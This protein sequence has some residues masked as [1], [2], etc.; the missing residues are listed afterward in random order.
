MRRAHLIH[1]KPHVVRQAPF[2]EMLVLVLI[3][4]DVDD[5]SA[6]LAARRGKVQNH[7]DTGGALI[8]GAPFAGAQHRRGDVR[9]VVR[10][11]ASGA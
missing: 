7:V 4:T 5:V 3:C 9:D 2:D 10:A 11:G 8:S 6:L 1:V